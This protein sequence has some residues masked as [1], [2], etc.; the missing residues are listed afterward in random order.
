MTLLS[1]CIHREEMALGVTGDKFG[2]MVTNV[3]GTLQLYC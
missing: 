2:Q 3:D 1:V